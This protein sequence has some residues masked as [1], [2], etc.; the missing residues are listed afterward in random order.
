MCELL[1]PPEKISTENWARNHLYLSSKESASY[2]RYNPDLT[3]WARFVFE[4]FDD[5]QVYKI[6]VQKSSQSA[7]TTIL[8]A[9][10]AKRIDIDPCPMIGMFA[11]DQAAREFDDEKFTP[12]VEVTPRLARL[13]P[14]HK[15]R[16]KDNRSKY[17]NFVGGFLKFVGS[18]RIGSVKSTP[19]PLVFAEEPDDC[20]Q[21]INGQG[22]SLF[23]LEE[24]TKTY[25]QK[26]II[27]GGTPTIAGI[28]RIDSLYKS[29]DQ[30]KFYVR[31]H[32]CAESHVLDWG[33]VRWLEEGD[34]PHEV[35]GTAQ[36]DTASYAC[37]HCG[38]LWSD[39]EKNRNVKK[40]Q[41]KSHALFYGVRGF[42]WNELYSPFHGSRLAELVRKY[43]TAKH[44]LANGDDSLMKIFVN[45]TL[46]LA[47]EY[48]SGLPDLEKLAEG[49]LDYA[50]YTVPRGGLVLTAGVDVQHDRLAV[51]IR[52]WGRG[53]EGWLVYW[54]EIY[55]STMLSYAHNPATGQA[56]LQGAWADLDLLLMKEFTHACGAV[57]RI[58]AVSIDCSDGQTSDAVYAYVRKRIGRGFMAVKGASADA[59]GK[60]EI[61]SQ[62]LQSV[63]T[64]NENIKA[65]KYGLRPFIVGTS[66]AKDLILG[67][68]EKA[69]R[70][71]LQGQGPGRM[72]T[73][74]GVRP[75]YFE[76]LTSEIKAPHKTKRNKRQ[77]Q[78]K[79]GVRNEALD[80]EVYALH[81]ARSLKI[82]LWKEDRWQAIE[83][84]MRQIDLLPEEFEGSPIEEQT[85]GNTEA[86]PMAKPIQKPSKQQFRK[87]TSRPMKR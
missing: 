80:C 39:L 51:V 7:W 32:H 78:Q 45:N 34:V 17:K 35:W 2:G 75:D 81:A 86:K 59:D 87:P 8:R 62:P 6:I 19:S 49:V 41:P 74:R 37:P 50:E 61:F 68:D 66:R 85:V 3:P 27:I 29:S 25:R 30:I 16:S 28:S 43:L 72:H 13:I 20:N 44:N 71:K 15:E 70:I 64:D 47:Y 40:L 9:Y 12:M 58:R 57:L 67:A 63:D 46:G 42:F 53:E 84:K 52:A 55:G 31:C 10:L 77:W 11:D 83:D 60:K 54:G 82:H 24:R 1:E 73:Y 56:E 69:G 26:K 76:Q 14:V 36:P 65:H 33:N 5:P 4:A 18:N 48:A 79:S 23:L 21:N 22:D 38:G